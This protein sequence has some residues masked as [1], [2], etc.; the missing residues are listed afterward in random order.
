MMHSTLE[1]MTTST[2]L[3]V[4]GAGAL[5][6]ELCRLLAQRG[7]SNVLVIDPD[8]L[9]PRNTRSSA[10]YLEAY[11]ELG[12]TAFHY[13]KA[14]LI[15]EVIR[16]KY[17]LP[18]QSLPIEIADAGLGL[19]ADYDL[20]LSCTDNSLARIETARAARVLKLPMLDGAVKGEGIAAGR[21][22]WFS[23]DDQSACYLCGISETRRA[24]LLAYAISTSLGCRIPEEAPAMTAAHSTL[25]E[26]AATMLNL[27]EDL[28]C[29]Q[30]SFTRHL[31]K[32]DGQ[33]KRE[34][35]H[36]SRSR[37]CP[38]HESS[39]AS[40]VSLVHDRSF[41]EAFSARD[42]SL[43]MFWPHCLKARCRQC[44][45]LWEPMQRVAQVRRRAACPRCGARGNCE[46]IEVV[47]SFTGID[48]IANFSPRQLNLP[49]QHLYLFRDIFIPARAEG[50]E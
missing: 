34:H 35:L 7:F 40:W 9:E 42:Q 6:S 43:Q 33:W 1:N 21:V 14:E 50:R 26:T 18:W 48:A 38:W 29:N 25:Q 2:R 46:P 16:R 28:P 36:L 47:E 24:E 19:L 8:L 12:E 3:V 17:A 11:G 41:R 10:V 44:S 30:S 20:L 23:P 13:R 31:E 5:G 4:I 37:T 39:S 22:S 45:H 49:E 27:L 15:V 32:K